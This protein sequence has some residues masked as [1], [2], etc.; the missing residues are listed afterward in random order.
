M[1][2]YETEKYTYVAVLEYDEDGISV[3]FPDIEE[4]YTCSDNTEKVLFD[5][6]E[7]LKLSIRSRI[8]DGENIP[9]PT[10]LKD[11]K[12][13]EGQYTSIVSVELEKEVEFDK[14]TLTIPHYLNEEAKK[15]GINFSQ[16]LQKALK[17][18]LL[19]MKK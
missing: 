9:K 19:D 17:E 13:G 8:N 3:F 14:K 7:V 16:V 1:K 18:M 12:I 4:A 15:A 6:Q 2:K 11:I 5:A 10:A